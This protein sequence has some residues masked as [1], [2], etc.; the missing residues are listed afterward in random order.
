MAETEHPSTWRTRYRAPLALA[1]VSAATVALALVF[2]PADVAVALAVVLTLTC[3]L[4][5]PLLRAPA[6][7]PEAPATS[8]G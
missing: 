8:A 2:G 4:A 3:A 5:T 7:H 1:A 6:A